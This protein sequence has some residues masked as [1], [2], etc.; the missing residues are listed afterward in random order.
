M[1]FDAH[2]DTWDTY[3]HAPITYGTGFR[4]AFEEGLLA[5]AMAIHVGVRG[6]IYDRFDL[7]EDASFGLKVIRAG[8]RDV[9]GIDGAVNVVRRRV[10]DTPISLSIDVDVL[11][12]AFAPGHRQA[13]DGRPDLPRTAAP[14]APPERG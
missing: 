1:H 14:A 5:E 12:P 4:R 11:D 6:P 8:D 13:G 7:S 2:L 3:F 9:P 10:G